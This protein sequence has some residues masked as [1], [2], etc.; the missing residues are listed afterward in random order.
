MI[1]APVA[2]AATAEMKLVGAHSTIN[3]VKASF[4]LLLINPFAG[5]GYTVVVVFNTKESCGAGVD[6]LICL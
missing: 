3:R 2:G 5:G 4:E 1:G 6:R